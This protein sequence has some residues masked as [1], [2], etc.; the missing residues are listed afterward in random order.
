MKDMCGPFGCSGLYFRI[1][2]LAIG[3]IRIVHVH[4]LCHVFTSEFFSS[5]L[6][7]SGVLSVF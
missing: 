7:R 2:C 1:A 4:I 3:W 6:A 5:V